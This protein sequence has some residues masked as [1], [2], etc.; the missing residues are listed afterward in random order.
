MSPTSGRARERGIA[1]TIPPPSQDLK[2]HGMLQD[3]GFLDSPVGPLTD[4]TLKNA[5]YWG[6]KTHG[7]H[8]T[9]KQ[10]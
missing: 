5:K 10:R 3:P 1:S 2:D 9:M 8:S 7:V 4:G 6:T